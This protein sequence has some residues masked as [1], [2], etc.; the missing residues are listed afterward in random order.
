MNDKDEIIRLSREQSEA[1]V[2]RNVA[3][4]EAMLSDDFLYTNS[5]GKVSTKKDYVRRL[6]DPTVVWERQV[7]KVEDVRVVG[8]TAVLIG[9]V[10][11]VRSL[12]RSRSTR[13]IEP[14]GFTPEPPAA[15]S[16]SLA[17]RRR[18]RAT[19]PDPSE[20]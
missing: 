12:G 20:E 13:L 15:G 4:M 3:A 18:F 17:T 19:R 14:Y 8:G 16:A 7:L 5:L 10:H 9:T 11:D 2:A 1:R 6:A